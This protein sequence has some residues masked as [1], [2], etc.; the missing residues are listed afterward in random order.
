MIMLLLQKHLW[1]SFKQFNPVLEG[2]NPDSLHPPH[3]LP[4]PP[5]PPFKT[6]CLLHWLLAIGGF[7]GVNCVRVT[8]NNTHVGRAFEEVAFWG[9]LVVRSGK[10][11]EVVLAGTS[12][13]VVV[14]SEF[15]SVLFNHFFSQLASLGN[16]SVFLVWTIYKKISWD[17]WLKYGKESITIRPRLQLKPINRS[18]SVSEVNTQRE[19]FWIEAHQ[20]VVSL[21]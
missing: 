14:F 10:I 21:R 5:I 19:D 8:W 2:I 16:V 13:K 17:K 18:A 4:T 3:L 7:T 9:F 1:E 15:L 20:T 11:R 12:V 6:T